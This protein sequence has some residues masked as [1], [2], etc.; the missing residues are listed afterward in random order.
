MR[1]KEIAKELK[2]GENQAANFVA[3]SSFR[4]QIWK[5]PEE[6]FKNIQRA[7][8]RKYKVIDHILYSWYKKCQASDNYVNGPI[9]KENAMKIKSSLDQP[10]LEGFKAS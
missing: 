7:N 10:G 9:L 5:L 2:I 8:H 1:H 6:R 3:K 4:S